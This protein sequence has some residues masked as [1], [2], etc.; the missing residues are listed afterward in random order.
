M[1]YNVN[2]ELFA[3]WAIGL[4][5]ISV[6]LYARWWTGIRNFYWDDV[7]LGSVVVSKPLLSCLMIY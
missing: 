2:A 3:S 5:I 1:G 7:C 6:R 4:V